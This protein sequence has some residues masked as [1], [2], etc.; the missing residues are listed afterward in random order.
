M[1]RFVPSVLFSFSFFLSLFQN[2]IYYRYGN[3]L[4][5]LDATYRTTKYALP[6]FFLAVKTNVG[7]SVVAEFI[8]QHET[9]KSIMQ[10]LRT[11]KGL[12]HNAQDRP[13]EWSWEPKFFM[14]DFCEREIVAI[15]EVFPGKMIIFYLSVIL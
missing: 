4:C 1:I 10:G 9:K 8:V 5:L 11:I 6:L 3:S 7:Y 14:T 2:V 15:E 13:A 12:L